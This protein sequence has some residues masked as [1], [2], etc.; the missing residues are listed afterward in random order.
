MSAIHFPN[1]ISVE[2]LRP[3]G[4]ASI[5][6]WTEGGVY[7]RQQ[8]VQ[9]CDVGQTVQNIILQGLAQTD[10]VV[11]PRTRPTDLPMGMEPE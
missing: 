8:Y 3:H 7:V 5:K 11:M 9:L 2:L 10:G 4:L 1:R 6:T